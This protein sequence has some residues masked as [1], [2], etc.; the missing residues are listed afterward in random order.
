MRKE[1]YQLY[2]FSYELERGKDLVWD[3]PLRQIKKGNEKNDMVATPSY[4]GK[5]DSTR[6]ID[7]TYLHE[8]EKENILDRMIIKSPLESEIKEIPDK[9]A[10]VPIEKEPEIIR[11]AKVVF[12]EKAIAAGIQGKVYLTL[13]LDLDGKVMRAEVEKSSG[14]SLLDKA[15]VD[16]C[17]QMLFTPALA[18]G[19]KPVRV[20][21]MYPVNFSLR[22][23]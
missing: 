2:N 21:I 1:G 11:N 7:S 12:P 3:V 18:P 9:G 19:G 16:A 10:Y 5:K 23:E 17:K 13:L 14:S 20:W 15:A 22:K 8:K 4:L 6:K